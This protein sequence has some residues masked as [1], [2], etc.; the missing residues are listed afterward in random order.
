MPILLHIKED[1]ALSPIRDIIERS[2]QPLNVVW[3]VVSLHAVPLVKRRDPGASILAFVPS[4]ESIDGF[5]AEGVNIVRLW[6]S[7]ITKERIDGIHQHGR[8]VAAMTGHRGEKVGDTTADRLLELRTLGIDWVLV[9]DVELA[10]RTL[11]HP[12][13]AAPGRPAE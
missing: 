9:N 7:W 5:V 13:G 11:K 4:P 8:L 2:G 10:E 6:D 1:E 3:G 12:C